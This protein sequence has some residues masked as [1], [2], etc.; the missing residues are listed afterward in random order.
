MKKLSIALSLIAAT[1]FAAC[2]GNKSPCHQ[3]GGGG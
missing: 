1:L 2:S 3:L